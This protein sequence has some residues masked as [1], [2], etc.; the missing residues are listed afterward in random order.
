MNKREFIKT[1]LLAGAATGLALKGTAEATYLSP[2]KKKIKNWVW[3]GPD[4]KDTPEQLNTRYAAFK[5][6][7]ITSVFF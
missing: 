7:G 4:P 6:A 1:G 3:I 5:A 2:K